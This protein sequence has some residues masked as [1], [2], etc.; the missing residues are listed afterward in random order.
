[1]FYNLLALLLSSKAQH[2]QASR[3]ALDGWY[4]CI[5]Y[6]SMARKPNLDV[7]NEKSLLWDNIDPGFKEELLK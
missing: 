4:A 6:Q 1:M 7:R 3:A 5:S 2:E